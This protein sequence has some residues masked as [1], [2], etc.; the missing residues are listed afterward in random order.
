ML[1][2]VGIESRA[3]DFHALHATVWANFTFAGS[4][5]PLDPCVVMLYWFLDLEI[6]WNQKQ[7]GN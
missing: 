6:F 4:L 5:R 3:S 7:M 2:P 1:P